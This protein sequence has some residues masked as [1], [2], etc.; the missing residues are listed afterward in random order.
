MQPR[1]APFVEPRCIDSELILVPSESDE[2]THE[3]NS[4]SLSY[5]HFEPFIAL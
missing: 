1:L 5:H 3:H 4:A 2:T